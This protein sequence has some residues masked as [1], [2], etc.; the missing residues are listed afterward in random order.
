MRICLSPWGQAVY[1][2]QL[3]IPQFTSWNRREME[4]NI[5]LSDS[6]TKLVNMSI[7]TLKSL[8]KYITCSLWK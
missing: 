7:S 6:L 4:G 1:N 5:G 3:H 8:S 2:S